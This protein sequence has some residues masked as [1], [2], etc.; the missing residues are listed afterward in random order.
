M[1]EKVSF[2]W[3]GRDCIAA[4]CFCLALAG[5]AEA[6][7]GGS[8]GGNALPQV[9]TPTITV[10]TTGS[11]PSVA[12]GALGSN[13]GVWFDFTQPSTS[14]AMAQL[15]ARLLRW[16]GG[17]AS[18]MYHWQ[19]NVG[20]GGQYTAPKATFD[21]FVNDIVK[22]GGYHLAVT[23][24]YG[25][26][27]ACTAG[28][29]AGEAAAWVA[30]TKRLG[31]TGLY[32]TV[33][34]EEYGSWEYDLHSLP[35]DSATYAGAVAGAKGYYAQV[36][37]QDPSAHV[38]VSVAGDATWDKVVLASAPYDFV[39]LHFY[40]QNPGSE[41]DT[42]LLT[43]GPSGLTALIKTV[44]S[45]LATAGK[46]NTPIYLGEYNSVSS[47]PGKQT[48]S[49]VNGLY[50]GMAIG[51]VLNAGLPMATLWQGIGAGCGTG[52]NNSNS[53]YGWQTFGSYG[54]MADNWPN[55]YSC[56]GAPNVPYGTLMPS[57]QAMA[58]A[59]QFALTGSQILPVTVPGTLPNV[60]AY[61][62]KQGTG[63]AVM[64]FNLDPANP[65]S[66][67]VQ[68]AN[69]GTK[70]FV[71]KTITYGKAQYDASQNNIWNGPVSASL[72]PVGTSATL[73]LPAWSM[74][75]LLLR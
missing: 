72:G 19:A 15:N 13:M 24:N 59:S 73:S 26:N 53:L 65:A 28:G 40:A 48:V 44:R 52:G 50:T 21:N 17:S 68:M 62:A 14:P 22:P 38:G 35:H 67:Q 71:A 1:R 4:F 10:N 45:E 57:G 51:E 3:R 37:A 47:M 66:L 11:G 2:I 29:D 25:S 39:E 5:A 30:H 64:L 54:Q 7:T 23:L 9:A 58:L 70:K 42:N 16:P 31:L 75:V 41:N 36:K 18:D 6:A 43:Q 61:A 8:A 27:I 33:G 20:C 56:V 63:Y 55:P 60:R 32:W 69:A 74:T 34:N 12:W 46:P 49:I